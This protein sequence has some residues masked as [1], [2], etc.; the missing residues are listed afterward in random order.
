MR[1]MLLTMILALGSVGGLMAVDV[2]TS[3]TTIS[4]EGENQLLGSFTL[5]FGDNTFPTASGTT[6]VYIRFRLS[7]A[8]GWSKTLVD[9]RNDAPGSVRR[10]INI[11][12]APTVPSVSMNPSMPPTAIQL[13]RLVE[14]EQSGW[15]RVTYP[16]TSWLQ[17]AGGTFSPS[18]DKEVVCTVGIRGETSVR[19]G[20]NT[21]SGGN[22]HALTGHLISTQYRADY[23]GTPGFGVGDIEE[24]NFI[25]FDQTT[26]GVESG[27]PVQGNNAGVAFTNDPTVARGEANLPCYE[28]HFD[29]FNYDGEP[30]QASLN[31]MNLYWRD[32]YRVK[33]E[34]I[35]L[36][37]SSDFEWQVGS[38]LF[39]TLPQVDPIYLVTGERGPDRVV[40][41]DKVHLLDEDLEVTV[42]GGEVWDVRKIYIGGVFVGYDMEL[43]EREYPIF[44]QLKLNGLTVS[45]EGWFSGRSVTL[46]ARAFYT[47]RAVTGNE[48]KDLGPITRRTLTIERGEDQFHR[49]ILP[50]TGHGRDDWD[51]EIQ[52]V[53]QSPV[54]TVVTGF[55]YQ[56]QGIHMRTISLA[57]LEGYGSMSINPAEAFGSFADTLSWL[58]ILSDQPVV[59]VGLVEGK[60]G[61]TLDLFSS[62][63][64]S[65]EVLYGPHI[66]V[67]TGLW[68]SRAYVIASEFDLDSAFGLR[69]PGEYRDLKSLR[70]PRYSVVLDNEDFR[71]GGTPGSWFKIEATDKAAS[72]IFFFERADNASQLTSISLNQ[73]P[74]TSYSFD[75]LG[76]ELNG[77]WNGLILFN[78][79]A[80][81]ISANLVAYN[82]E[83]DKLGVA[84]VVVPRETRIAEVLPAFLPTVASP[85]R[86]EIEASG[87]LIAGLLMGRQDQE[88][89]THIPGDNVSGKRFLLPWLP[90]KLGR[91]TGLA[92]TNTVNATV[93]AELWPVTANGEL[94]ES[95]AIIVP[96]KGKS[97][98]LLLDLFDDLN[99]Y[100][101]MIIESN[102]AIRIFG[103]TGNDGQLATVP[104]TPIQ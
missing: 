23:R 87:E 97:L 88:I 102:H 33:A 69:L 74:M 43:M 67:N 93:R 8:V 84:D 51:L 13:V 4:H 89:L 81:D 103:I 99:D 47:N 92:L 10:P 72:G 73:K 83:G 16:T 41:D 57:R 46:T 77:W 95:R 60:D 59:A 22:E 28:F 21:L 94:G 54:P 80:F 19:T 52:I 40:V 25:A 85:S 78:P 82:E 6:P 24:L 11:A 48:L 55:F 30:Y 91:W 71:T 3:I 61:Q 75:H 98:T 90:K 64:E 56:R 42:S 20:S 66:P 29:E 17:D 37:N 15:L 70:A 35:Y 49:A 53:N 5:T 62:V 38:R 86:L 26:K 44:G 1:K 7:S 68:Q 32:E 104:V 76:S 36:T 58:E 14:G 31:R 18:P 65:E 39:L 101:S 27:L 45:A 9:L 34:P 50:F 63:T 79:G 96:P 2:S 12:L 100:R